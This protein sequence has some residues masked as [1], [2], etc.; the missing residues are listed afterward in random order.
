MATLSLA[1]FDVLWSDLGLG[2]VPF[3]LEVPSHGDTLDERARIKAVTHRVL[4]RDGLVRSGRPVPELEDALRLLAAPQLAV[5][6]VVMLTAGGERPRKALAVSRGRQA[7]LAV[8]REQTVRLSEVRDTAVIMSVVDLVPGNRP[9]PGRSITLSASRPVEPGNLMR[10]AL[11]QAGGPESRQLKAVLERP[12][13]RA[14]ILGLTSRTPQGKPRR[15]PG[16]VWVDN[17]QGRYALSVTRGPDGAEWTTLTPADNAR[18][19][20]RLGELLAT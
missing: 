17:D 1:G 7:V 4:E 18:L 20:A 14:G 10:P 6:L 8:Q 2:A 16:V 9:G 19:A 15:L 11:E 13:L 12:L 5:S 3:P